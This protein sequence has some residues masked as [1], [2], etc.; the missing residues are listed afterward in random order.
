[1]HPPG[2][3]EGPCPSCGT[4]PD[5][6]YSYFDPSQSF[7]AGGQ[8]RAG[9]SLKTQ[10]DVGEGI[11][12]TLKG[13]PGYGPITWWS[14]A[15]NSPLDGSTR[16]WGIEVKTANVDNANW[17]FAPRPSEAASKNAMAAERGLKGVLGVLVVL[18]YR[19]SLA[20]IYVKEFPL[21]PW[22]AGNGQTRSGIGFFRASP[23]GNQKPTVSRLI[24]EVPFTNPFIKSTDPTPMDLPF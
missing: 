24:A 3:T 2:Q 1:M 18:D 5:E 11:V 17:Q 8:T 13:I 21:G 16:E 15:Y 19:R 12:K 20:D 10:G 9:L 6:E 23:R 7:K 4:T 22:R 14:D